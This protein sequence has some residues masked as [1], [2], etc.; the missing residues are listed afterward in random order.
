VCESDAIEALLT[1]VGPSRVMYGSDDLPVGVLRGK[2]IS[3]GYAWAYLSPNNHSLDLSHCNDQMTFTRYEQLRAMRR[4]CRRLDLT[5]S[6][7]E[8]MFCNTALRLVES[9]RLRRNRSGIDR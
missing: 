8:D 3:F 4:A 5:R 6:Q 7:I 1:A 9:T 2:Y